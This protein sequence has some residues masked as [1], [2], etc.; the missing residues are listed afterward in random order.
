[1]YRVLPQKL[2]LVPGPRKGRLSY[3]MMAKLA[4]ASAEEHVR[5]PVGSNGIVTL[6]AKVALP[7]MIVPLMHSMFGCSCASFAINLTGKDRVTSDWPG[8]LQ[9]HAFCLT[10][11]QLS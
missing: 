5:S 6:Y 8:N 7:S 11:Q 1:M 3:D 10:H 2:L 4:L 9:A